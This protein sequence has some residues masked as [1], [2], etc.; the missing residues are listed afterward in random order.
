[1]QY[2]EYH[3]YETQTYDPNSP[4]VYSNQPSGGGSVLKKILKFLG[5]L[6]ILGLIGGLGYLYYTS[7]AK[8]KEANNK[9]AGL[10]QQLSE[11]NSKLEAANKELE[12]ANEDTSRFAADE[13]INLG[14]KP[15][16]I[17]KQEDV[18][19]LPEK[20]P[21]SFKQ[22]LSGM[23]SVSYEGCA[24][25]YKIAKFSATNIGGSQGGVDSQTLQPS[26][27]CNGYG[28]TVTWYL[29]DERWQAIA[30]QS[31]P[32]CDVLAEAKIYSEFQAECIDS[33]SKEMA[34]N[35]V[36]SLKE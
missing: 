20:I 4:T 18:D 25:T 3:Q 13:L 31:A 33:R 12:I 26:D 32:T 14:D 27:K 1:M 11:A 35:P 2:N 15:V 10:E 5:F 16:E 7:Q 34:K 29:Q 28:A 6:I 19:K 24:V 22:F 9:V 21:Q 30:G 36:G 17:I 8:A 23:M